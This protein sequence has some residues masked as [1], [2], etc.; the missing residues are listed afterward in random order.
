MAQV[1][2]STSTLQVSE[3][4]LELLIQGHLKRE[5]LYLGTP[6]IY[7]NQDSVGQ[8]FISRE[9][10]AQGGSLRY[11]REHTSQRAYTDPLSCLCA[12][13][14]RLAAE[15]LV[16]SRRLPTLRLESIKFTVYNERMQISNNG[17]TPRIQGA[18]EFYEALLTAILTFVQPSSG[19]DAKQQSVH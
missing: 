8:M 6:T 14:L 2:L 9:V 7:W 19:N 10:Y 15:T 17:E 18:T 4:P 11:L 16:V 5:G 13:D 12:K 3:A 1:T